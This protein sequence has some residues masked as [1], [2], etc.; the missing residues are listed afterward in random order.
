MGRILERWRVKD[1]IGHRTNLKEAKGSAVLVTIA[2]RELIFA[3]GATRKRW[4]GALLTGCQ[5]T[6]VWGSRGKKTFHR[7][8]KKEALD[9]P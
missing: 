4:A 6:R 2:V 1:K 7:R 9:A 3:T 5:L 8:R